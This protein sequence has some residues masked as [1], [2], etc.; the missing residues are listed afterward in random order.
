MR[1]LSVLGMSI[2]S[3]LCC[4]APTALGEDEPKKFPMGV[5]AP[6]A[7]PLNTTFTIEGKKVLLIDG[8]HE[9]QA[10]QGSATKIQTLVVGDP[11]MEDLDG[12]G[13]EDAGLFLLQT[14]G[15]SGTFYYVAAAVNWDGAYTGTNG[16][17]LG[18]RIAPRN[19]Q[20]SH[21][22]IIA[23]YDDRR[24]DEPMSARPSVGRTK[25]LAFKRGHLQELN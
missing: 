11:V 22:W 3:L 19:I 5:P 15:G 7:D 21:G 17:F 18:D 25:H 8:C 9:E 1:P 24:P 6:S 13:D 14:R 10:A 12:D 16:I 4:I 2:I 20:M 23:E